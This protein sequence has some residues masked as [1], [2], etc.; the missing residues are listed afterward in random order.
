MTVGGSCPLHAGVFSRF[1]L[2]EGET[3]KEMDFA[4]KV[5]NGDNVP[6]EDEDEDEEDDEEEEASRITNTNGKAVHNDAEEEIM[7]SDDEDD[8]D[9][10]DEVVNEE[11]ESLMEIN[12]ANQV[13]N[14]STINSQNDA[15]ADRKPSS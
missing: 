6:E 5:G 8:D 1:C 13:K 14:S 3:N 7:I 2:P 11:E 10:D 9:D 12:Q 4:K 15:V